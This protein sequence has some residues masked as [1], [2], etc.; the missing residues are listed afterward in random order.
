LIKIQFYFAPSSAKLGNNN[1]Q[2]GLSYF[3]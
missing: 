3:Y 1:Q 2:N